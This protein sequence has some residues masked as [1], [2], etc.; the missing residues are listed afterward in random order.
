MLDA[1]NRKILKVVGK[2]SEFTTVGGQIRKRQQ[3][4]Q[5]NASDNEHY[6]PANNTSASDNRRRPTQGSTQETSRTFNGRNYG[7]GF[8]NHYRG[9]RG[10]TRGRRF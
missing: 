2:E 10:Q 8:G 6:A 5:H 7:G 3:R 9:G 1:N 4:T